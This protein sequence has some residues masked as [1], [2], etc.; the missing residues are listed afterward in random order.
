MLGGKA[1]VKGLVL[2]SCLV[3]SNAQ[4]IK[5]PSLQHVLSTNKNLTKFYGLMQEKYPDFL[6]ILEAQN[7]AEQPITVLAPSN[8]AFVKIPDSSIGEAFNNNDTDAIREV[9]MYHVLPGTH[10]TA[11]FSTSFQFLATW[12]ADSSATNVTSGQRVGVVQQTPYYIFISGLGTRSTITTADIYFTGGVLHIIDMPVIPPVSFPETAE[13]FNTTAFLGAAYQNLTLANL[14][15]LTSDITIFAPVNN[16]FESINTSPLISSNSTLS[17]IIQYHIII[18]PS[19]PLYSPLLTNGTIFTTLSGT[20]LT[21]YSASNSIFIN[22]ARLLQSDL[23]LANGVMHTIDSVQCPCAPNVQPNPELATAAEVI[24]LGSKTLF[25]KVPFTTA[26][27]DLTAT[28]SASITGSSST[29]GS[30]SVTTSSGYDGAA[31]S[32]YSSGGATESKKSLA[33]RSNAGTQMM[34]L[35]CLLSF[36]ISIEAVIMG[37]GYI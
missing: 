17:P 11:S 1:L 2:L 25:G 16:A 34:R 35:F 26:I 24:P 31:S 27:P 4:T 14:M 7:T 5:T 13:D 15:N 18:S 36:V 3:I 23:L 19:G 21:V 37:L 12:L 28:L 10:S 9:F 29:S 6:S 8:D 22:N 32:T 20:N 33:T 30:G